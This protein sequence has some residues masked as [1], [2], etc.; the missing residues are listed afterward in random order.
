[1]T[2]KELIELN[3]Y[4]GDITVTIRDSEGKN[5]IQEYHIGVNAGIIP[6]Y[7]DDKD[8]YEEIEINTFDKGKDYYQIL[9]SRVPKQ[10]LELRVFAY[11]IW[12]SYRRYL[13]ASH[14]L[15]HVHITVRQG[16]NAKTPVIKEKSQEAKKEELEGQINLEDFIKN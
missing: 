1:M 6:V 5:K 11:R 15:E 8:V 14:G 16:E 13:S 3:D 7:H 12:G 9:V 10:I 2:I 4:I